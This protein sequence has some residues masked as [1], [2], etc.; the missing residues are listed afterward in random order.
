MTNVLHR[1]AEAILYKENGRL[2]KERVQKNYRIESIDQYLR[3]FRTRREAKILS[4]GF[5]F[6]PHVFEVD[7]K[8]MRIVMGY[9][10]G[11]LLRDALPLMDVEKLASVMLQ[12]GASIA[13]LHRKDVMHGDLTT[14]NMILNE[15]RVYFIDFGLSFTSTRA[16]D[17][18][19][20][21][22]LFRQALQS[23]HSIIAERC[24][25][26]VLE[27]YQEYERYAEVLQR[28]EKVE[29]RGR[30]KRKMLVE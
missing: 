14:S 11:E 15:D 25:Q 30:Y 10:D 27:G 23:T 5:S 17:R 22:H 21:L 29:Q 9:I 18:A 19:I 24:F 13:D 16:E 8:K 2:V 1:G 3:G 4:K 7:E 20:D 28:L 12:V 6:V 26:R